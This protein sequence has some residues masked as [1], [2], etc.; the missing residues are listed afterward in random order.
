MQ[1]IQLLLQSGVNEVTIMDALNSIPV[2]TPQ[3]HDTV[4]HVFPPDSAEGLADFLADDFPLEWNESFFAD[5]SYLTLS[6]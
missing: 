6:F 1:R 5:S 4:A 3:Q 2:P